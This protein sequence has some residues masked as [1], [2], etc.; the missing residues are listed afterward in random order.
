MEEG[1]EAALSRKTQPRPDARIFDG[2][3]E[4]KRIALAGSEPPEGH[5]R[6]SLRL[7]EKH[8]VELGIVDAASDSTIGRVLKKTRSKR[9]RAAIG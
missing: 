2:G 7:L 6:W 3:K 9:T 4:A 8:V 5:A 1:L